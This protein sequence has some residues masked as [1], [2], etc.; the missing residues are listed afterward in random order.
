MASVLKESPSQEIPRRA[1]A[2]LPLLLSLNAGYVDA[3]GYLALQGVFTAHVTGNFVTLGAS[4]ALGT[5]GAIAKLLAL[6]VFCALI[7]ATRLLD[8]ALIQRNWPALDVLLAIKV[9]VL[10]CGAAL[11]I[12]FGPFRNADSWQAVVSAMVLVSAMAMQNALHRVHLGT[13]PPSTIMTGTTTQVMIDLADRIHRRAASESQPP[14]RLAQMATSVLIFAT[15]CA[16]AAFLYSRV[17]VM[18]FVVPPLV[19]SLQLLV[20]L[21]GRPTA[22]NPGVA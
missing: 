19:G 12:H 13:T 3:A 18:C 14:A 15:G 11:A 8:S 20:H 6:P 17:G 16:A 21:L 9:L 2:V 4:L 10:A 22:R 1:P 7:F 5:S